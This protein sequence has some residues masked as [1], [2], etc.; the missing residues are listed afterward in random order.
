MNKIQLLLFL[1]IM[2]ACFAQND[3][4]TPYSLFGLGVENKT[5]TGGLTGLG[6]TGIAQRNTDEINIYNPASLGNVQPKTFLYE[7]GLNGMYSTIKTSNVSENTTDFNISHVAMAFPVK[8]NIGMSVGLLPYTKVGYDVDIE[9]FIEGSDDIYLER[10]TGSGGLSKVYWATGANL[11]DKLAI[12]V[13]LSYLFGSINQETQVV[14]NF[15]VSITDANYYNGLRLKAGLQ[16]DL[17][18]TE[19]NEV[20][21]GAVVELPT[22]LSGNQE[23]YSYRT[24]TGGTRVVLDDNEE[25]E[26]DDFELPLMYGLGVTGKLNKSLTT[27]FDFKKMYWDNTTQTNNNESYTN[28]DIY[29]FGAEYLP[30]ERYTYWG[31]V[32]YRLGFNY[33]TGFLNISN[34]KIDSYFA[35]VGLGMPLSD[36]A[37]LNISYSYGREGT[38]S[39]GLIE[40]NFHKI[41]INLSF[42]GNWFNKSKFY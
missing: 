31:R 7:F 12:G 32:K 14:Q 34:Q 42:I 38:V 3:T 21:L 15:A 28:Q 10:I 29:A 6:N 18:K 24:T 2:P 8:K 16:Y 23:R 33:S 9:N 36:K 22:N 11:T 27:S 5:A 30:F 1:T 4:S 13:D 35:S 37:K 20:T 26:L 40:E 19:H 25:Y 17:I 39:N 41:T